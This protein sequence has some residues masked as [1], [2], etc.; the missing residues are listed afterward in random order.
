MGYAASK[1]GTADICIFGLDNDNN[2]SDRSSMQHG[3]LAIMPSPAP[4]CG[5]VQGSSLL[6]G[7]Q[8]DQG[9]HQHIGEL[10]NWEV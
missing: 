2:I 3:L 6:H 4:G 9:D 1:L 10:G 5:L 8:G 7:S